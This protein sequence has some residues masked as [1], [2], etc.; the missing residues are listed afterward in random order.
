MQKVS[1]LAI[2]L[3]LVGCVSLPD[4][5][6]HDRATVLESEAAGEWPQLEKEFVDK[7]VS[8]KPKPFPA[9]KEE[10]SGNKVYNVLGGDIPSPKGHKDDKKL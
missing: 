5:Y 2:S 9:G 6:L 4:V 8:I 10:L 1:L 7:K 3:G